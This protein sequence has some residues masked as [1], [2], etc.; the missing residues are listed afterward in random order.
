MDEP[1]QRIGRPATIAAVVFLIL[2]VA[3]ILVQSRRPERV[4]PPAVA[5]V[6]KVEPVAARELP[7][8]PLGRAELIDL[9]ASA[10]DAYAAGRPDL[11]NGAVVAGRRLDLRLPFGCFGP[12]PESPAAPLSWDYDAE[13][14][15][16]RVTARPE[17]WTEQERVRALAPAA[18]AIEGFWIERPW[19]REAV[20]PAPRP[21]AGPLL[22]PRPRPTLGVA[23]IFLPGSSR[24]GRRDGKPYRAVVKLPAGRPV[25]PGG[26]VLVLQGRIGAFPGIGPIGCW[27][28]SSELRPVCLIAAEIDRVAIEAPDGERLGEWPN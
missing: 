23:Q 24:V 26:Y 19:L 18:E 25:S 3:G 12:A 10:A 7:S 1:R 4:P 6:E 11:T 16:L 17:Q 27:S 28:E 15:V 21:L 5:P 22:L 20:C 2:L 9:A 13:K 8:P 14:R